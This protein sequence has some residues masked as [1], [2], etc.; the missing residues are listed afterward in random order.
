[1]ALTSQEMSSASETINTTK[2]KYS[3]DDEPSAKRAKTTASPTPISVTDEISEPFSPTDE[4]TNAQNQSKACDD[5]NGEPTEQS[6]GDE[7]LNGITDLPKSGEVVNRHLPRRIGPYV[8]GPKL[9]YSPIDSIT[10]HLARHEETHE[11]VQLK[12]CAV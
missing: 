5:S 4:L 12:V 2:P 1:M 8:L 7:C 9:N 10:M 3:S 11:Y 6:N